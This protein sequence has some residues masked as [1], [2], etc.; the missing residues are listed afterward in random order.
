MREARTDFIFEFTTPYRL[1]TGAIALRT[2]SLN[3]KALN[4]SVEQTIVIVAILSVSS[5]VFNS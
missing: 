5:K 1:S 2:P 3:H 4:D